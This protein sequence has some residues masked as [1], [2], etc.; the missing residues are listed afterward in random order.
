MFSRSLVC[1]MVID[2]A[3]RSPL[4]YPEDHFSGYSDLDSAGGGAQPVMVGNRLSAQIV[5]KRDFSLSHLIG[6]LR[7]YDH[8]LENTDTVGGVSDFRFYKVATPEFAISTEVK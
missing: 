4:S 7:D 8:S 6:F 2:S 3:S 5:V 1:L